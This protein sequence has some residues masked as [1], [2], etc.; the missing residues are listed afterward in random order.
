MTPFSDF[1]IKITHILPDK[2]AL[3][4]SHDAFRRSLHS[5]LSRLRALNLP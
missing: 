4:L 1:I 5:F 2:E 3:A